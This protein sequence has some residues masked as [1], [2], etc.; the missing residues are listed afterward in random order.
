MIVTC[1]RL[2]GRCIENHYRTPHTGKLIKKETATRHRVFG[3]IPFSSDRNIV[4]RCCYRETAQ[5]L[6]GRLK[7]VP[8]GNTFH[9]HIHTNVSV[10][11]L[12]PLRPIHHLLPL[13]LS[14]R[15]NWRT[16]CNPI[17]KHVKIKVDNLLRNCQH[18]SKILPAR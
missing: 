5:L 13:V 7:R 4:A 17:P 16:V 6:A 10:V 8:N 2:F 11:S 12:L 1:H 15:R 18:M 14:D 9:G 3:V